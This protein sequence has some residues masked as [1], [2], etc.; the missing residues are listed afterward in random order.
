MKVK[1]PHQGTS[2]LGLSAGSNSG[3]VHR[4]SQSPPNPKS[5]ARANPLLP[6]DP[7]ANGQIEALDSRN[8]KGAYSILIVSTHNKGSS[9][10]RTSG[11]RRWRG[12]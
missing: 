7:I 3:F 4:R 8:W 6:V 9:S 11:S 2:A 12:R 5:S 1:G 10:R